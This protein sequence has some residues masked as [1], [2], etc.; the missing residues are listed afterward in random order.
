MVGAAKSL[1]NAKL[2]DALNSKGISFQ[3]R[4]EQ[5]A[6]AHIYLYMPETVNLQYDMMYDTTDLVKVGGK[7]LSSLLPKADTL[8]KT[9]KLGDAVTS[10]INASV[11]SGAA[12]L[13]TQKAGYA[14][15]PQLQLLFQGIGFRTHQM[16]FTFTPYSKQENDMVQRIIKTF[17]LHS[18]PRIVRGA[19]GMFFV[20]PSKFKIKFMFNNAENKNLY[21]LADC[22]ITN[23]DVNHAPNGYS[24]HT[25]GSPVQTTLTLQLKEITL[26]DREMIEKEGY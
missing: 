13:L 25:D 20:P 1:P 26:V 4:T 17:R 11:N 23:V 15:N 18:A 2:G 3:P 10:I 14:V 24:T 5:T 12:S 9:K 7:M 21:K 19:G 6:K 8:E 22:V 16:S